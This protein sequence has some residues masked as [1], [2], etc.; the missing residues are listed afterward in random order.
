M[1]KVS[2][3]LINPFIIGIHSIPIVQ[4]QV[5]F[6]FRKWLIIQICPLNP[7]QK[8]EVCSFLPHPPFPQTMPVN[9]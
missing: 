8:R 1:Y 7:A 2:F 4:I 5:I 3:E 9:L 6:D